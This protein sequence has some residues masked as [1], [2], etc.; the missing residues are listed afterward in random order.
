MTCHNCRGDFA[1]YQG[2]TE[3]LL[4]KSPDERFASCGGDAA[5]RGEPIRQ[6][7]LRSD[8]V[9]GRTRQCAEIYRAGPRK[10]RSSSCRFA[11][12]SVAQV[13]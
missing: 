7:G 10:S 9:A 12:I 6:G 5:L 1:P 2:L 13:D 4:A 8:P 11:L 3:C